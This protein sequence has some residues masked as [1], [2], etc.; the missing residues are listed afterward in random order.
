MNIGDRLLNYEILAVLGKGGFGTVYLARDVNLDINVAVKV[1]NQELT[2]SETMLNRLRTGARAAARLRHPN[3]QTVHFLGRDPVT[4]LDF[5][6]MEY[7]SGGTLRQRIALRPLPM[8]ESLNIF[9]AICDAVDFAH[10]HGVIHRDLKPDNIMF[11]AESKLVVTDFDLARI[12]SEVSRSA[13]GQTLGT[14]LYI[15]PEQA[16]GDDVDHMTD[17]Y[18]LGVMLFE[19]MTG[20]WPFM[21]DNLTEILKG[22]LY[23]PPPRPSEFN[24]NI[25]ENIDDAVMRALAKSPHDRI[26]SAAE[27]ACLANDKLYAPQKSIELPAISADEVL[28]IATAPTV[29]VQIPEAWLHISNGAQAG[30]RFAVS[31]GVSI[32]YGKKK[33]DIHLDDPYVSRAHARVDRQKELYEL[34]D[35]KSRNGTKVNGK[36]IEPYMPI[37]LTGG[38]Q[39]EVGDTVLV[40]EMED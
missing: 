14:L 17:I 7:L 6:V 28:S 5:M 39:I 36:K 13:V 4:Q 37:R 29:K 16:R 2:Q 11:D 33:N 24:P 38:D 25:T 8:T 27:L 9:S 32:G 19:L 31:K 10:Q 12:T 35:L 22:H 21:G 30:Q 40:F 34:M 20:R 1:M 23:S 3:I 26:Q 15:S 18:S